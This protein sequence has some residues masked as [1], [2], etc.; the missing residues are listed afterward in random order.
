VFF[1]VLLVYKFLRILLYSI[2][3]LCFFV[4]NKGLVLR[5]LIFVLVL[6]VFNPLVAALFLRDGRLHVFQSVFEVLTFFVVFVVVFGVFVL[7]VRDKKF[8]FGKVNYW[9][10]FVSLLLF[11]V[12]FSVMG[13]F[14][15][16]LDEGVDISSSNV[17]D[18]PGYINFESSTFLNIPLLTNTKHVYSSFVLGDGER[19]MKVLYLDKVPV[20]DV[21][22]FHTSWQD[23]PVTKEN[24]GG[25]VGV[26]D[27]VLNTDLRVFLDVNNKT[28]D[29]TNSYACLEENNGYWVDVGLPKGT[30]VVGNNSFV[31]YAQNNSD[32]LRL[33]SQEVYTPHDS[34]KFDGK[35][36]SPEMMDFVL[37]VP[38]QNSFWFSLLFRLSFVFKVIGV[39]LLVSSLFGFGFLKQVWRNSKKELFF[40]V[41]CC[42]VIYFFYGLS[43]SLWVYLSKI[44]S[45]LVYWLLKLSFLSP[46]LDLSNVSAPSVGSSGF[47]V[48]VADVCS[49]IESLSLFT[50]LF[51]VVLVFDWKKLNFWNVVPVFLVG[52]FG[53]F[54][55]NVLRIYLLILVGTF[56]SRTFALTL[57]H[58]FAAMLLFIF[59]FAFFVY[60]SKKFLEK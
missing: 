31:F 47:V 20:K 50:F 12:S 57:F 38:Q 8:R 32:L 16:V 54:L 23:F 11:A 2:F 4:F 30:L 53:V 48:T 43:F 6:L 28:F 5:Y 33:S 1:V 7:L 3:C 58:S 19:L 59:Y 46:F 56:V 60:F 26:N 10:L 55:L 18:V 24:V 9:F 21:V 39:F 17:I 52:L 44:T 15:K 51:F 14:Y 36:W 41:V 29:I 34:F 40:S 37:F 35:E 25:F 49:G 27:N 42:F 13:N 45:F 22:R